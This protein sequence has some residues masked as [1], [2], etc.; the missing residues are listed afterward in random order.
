MLLRRVR[1]HQRPPGPRWL[2]RLG[3]CGSL[4]PSGSVRVSCCHR[5]CLKPHFRPSCGQ[6]RRLRWDP[7]VGRLRPSLGAAEGRLR[8]S[9][10]AASEGLSSR[11]CG[12]HLLGAAMPRVPVTSGPAA[13]RLPLTRGAHPSRSGPWG[14]LAL[15]KVAVPW[16]LPQ[17]QSESP[18]LTGP[19]TVQ[20]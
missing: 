10:A 9:P 7:R 4:G 1:W 6:H 20:A 2:S 16:D 17:S 5:Q 13:G 3:P 14:S 15:L 18:Q 8:Q 12:C 19:G 11:V